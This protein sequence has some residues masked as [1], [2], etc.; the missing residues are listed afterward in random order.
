VE[1]DLSP[2]PLRDYLA[3]AGNTRHRREAQNKIAALRD[4]ADDGRFAA[5]VAAAARKRSPAPLRE[6]LDDDQNT[7]HRREA[8]DRLAAFLDDPDE[9]DFASAVKAVEA[10]RQPR[11]LRDYLAGPGTRRHRR[12]AQDKLAPFFDQA[13]AELKARRQERPAADGALIAAFSDLLAALKQADR[14]V[15]TVGFKGAQEDAP[16]SQA[17]RDKEAADYRH[18]L[19]KHPTELG[20]VAEASPERT[21]VLPRGE[22]FEAGPTRAREAAVVDRLHAALPPELADLLVLRRAE[23]G[24]TPLIEVAYRVTAPGRLIVSVTNL[25]G[26]DGQT[27]QVIKGL[28]RGYDVEW[29]VTFRPPGRGK[30]SVI[31]FPAQAALNL[32]Y[33]GTT[34]DPDWANYA[35]L[36]YG[37]FHDFGGRLSKSFAVDAPPRRN[38]W[39]FADVAGR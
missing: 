32:R 37:A 29:T 10:E 27:Q 11:P 19:A 5:A 15:V 1:S 34:S 39:K 13:L 31:K 20:R 16:A 9:L 21:A 18:F 23:E 12:E 7:R 28:M 30:A 22:T 24:E 2:A 33:S 17:A 35:V 14:P 25:R 3:A 36:L 6:Y 8:R 26:P 4:V 38:N